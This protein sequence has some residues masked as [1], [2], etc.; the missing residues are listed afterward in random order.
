MSEYYYVIDTR[1]PEQDTD[2]HLFVVMPV[3]DEDDQDNEEWEG[4]FSHLKNIL[5]AE[6]KQLG[7]KFS[8]LLLHATMKISDDQ[9]EQIQEIKDELSKI[10]R[11]SSR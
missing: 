2:S 8:N 7:L 3:A 11:K 9:K 10:K 4:G 5:R 1:S 6:I